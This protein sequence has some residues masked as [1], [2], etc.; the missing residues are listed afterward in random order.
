MKLS[1]FLTTQVL[2]NRILIHYLALE[3][4]EEQGDDHDEGET[5]QGRQHDEHRL[6][7][8]ARRAWLAQV[9]NA[10]CVIEIWNFY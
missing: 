3:F 8:V 5:S 1:V 4:T 7:K 9:W 2:L 6:L 10:R